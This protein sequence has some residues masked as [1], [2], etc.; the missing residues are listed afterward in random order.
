MKW[1]SF[2]ACV[3]VSRYS[4]RGHLGDQDFYTLLG[5][6]KP[7]LFHVLPCT[8]NRQLCQWWKDKGYENI[9]H[10]YFDCL[11]TVKIWHGNC[12]TPIPWFCRK[13][14][15]RCSFLVTGSWF[16]LVYQPVLYIFAFPKKVY[17]TKLLAY[18]E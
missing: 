12:D 16:S 5:F 10:K 8:W 13:Y 6:E 9:F 4:F 15:G 14:F 17:F 1:V 2:H 18:L 3:Y 7:S 11:G